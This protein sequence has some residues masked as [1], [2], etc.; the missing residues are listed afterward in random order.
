MSLEGKPA[1]NR[2][3][4]CSKVGPWGPLQATEAP[5]WGSKSDAK[6]IER[7]RFS[8]L[9][10]GRLYIFSAFQTIPGVFSSTIHSL[11]ANP[12]LSSQ[13]CYRIRFE[14]FLDSRTPRNSTES[15]ETKI[16][17]FSLRWECSSFEDH[18]SDSMFCIDQIVGL[19]IVCFQFEV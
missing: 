8:K 11:I 18:V 10:S 4:Y 17:V 13:N 12:T 19:P 5:A 2:V 7:F 9:F 15:M 3:V 14:V 16:K 1:P 6:N